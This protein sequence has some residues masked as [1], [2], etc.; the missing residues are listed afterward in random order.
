[1]N[2]NTAVKERTGNFPGF[3][4]V[5]KNVAV[6][7]GIMLVALLLFTLIVTYTDFPEEYISPIVLVL[8]VVSVML[9]GVLT[10]LGNRTMGWLCGAVS[11]FFYMVTLYCLSTLVFDYPGFSANVIAMFAL[12]IF[13]GTLGGI[14]GINMKGVKRK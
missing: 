13:A 12:G 14:V 7:Y 5:L 10:A 8:T 9:S 1:M 4:S 3:L 2:L 11:G 6:T